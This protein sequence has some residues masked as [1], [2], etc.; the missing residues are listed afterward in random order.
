M[1]HGT[2]DLFHRVEETYSK[3][4]PT[5]ESSREKQYCHILGQLIIDL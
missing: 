1:F 2:I 3:L 4:Q 5:Q